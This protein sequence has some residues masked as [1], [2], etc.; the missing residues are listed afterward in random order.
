MSTD[1]YLNLS[2][3]TKA[4]LADEITCLEQDLSLMRAEAIDLSR[5]LSRA[6]DLIGEMGRLLHRGH[7]GPRSSCLRGDCVRIRIEENAL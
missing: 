5:R 1:T 4:Q 6:R 3:T 7:D 2:K